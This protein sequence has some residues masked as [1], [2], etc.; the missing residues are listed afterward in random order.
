M[1]PH[2]FACARNAG[3]HC[4]L[5]LKC[6]TAA[7]CGLP[8]ALQK[9]RHSASPSLGTQQRCSMTIRNKSPRLPAV[10]VATMRCTTILALLALAAFALTALASGTALT[11]SF[12]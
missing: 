8:V 5:A 9:T 3:R 11:F 6:E 2:R 12:L 4:R 1:Q 7:G 10:A